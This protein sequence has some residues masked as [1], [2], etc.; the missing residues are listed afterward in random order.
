MV[1][2]FVLLSRSISNQQKGLRRLRRT[3]HRALRKHILPA[4]AKD[5]L[6]GAWIQDQAARR[7]LESMFSTMIVI[8]I[9]H[10]EQS[11][12]LLVK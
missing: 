9:E 11:P 3:T 2:P 5:R 1:G 4:L 7:K 12:G 10:V 6:A 8:K